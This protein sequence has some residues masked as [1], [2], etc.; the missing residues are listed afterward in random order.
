M[1]GIVDGFFRGIHVGIVEDEPPSLRGLMQLLEEL[2]CVVCWAARDH[3]EAR[4]LLV[5]DLP[6]VVFVDLKLIQG[7]NDFRPGWRLIRE[8]RN[9]APHLGI[10]IFSGTPVV[11]EIVLEAIDLACSY[12]I[13]QDMWG[14]ERDVV[15]AALLA[16]RTRSVMLSNEVAGCIDGI[17]SKLKGPGLLTER[18]VDVLE[19]V[20]DGLSNREIAEELVL[21]ETT[22]KTHV[23][24]VL[25]KLAVKN[26][27]KAADWY[28]EHYG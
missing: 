6:E 22:V 12:I 19:L 23:S 13:K 5:S 17:V 26:R 4:G 15:M 10:V 3:E 18:E 25:S 9:R 14:H 11:D 16:T 24:N 21:S 20:A 2:G 1:S 8:L 28:R 27:G 7:T